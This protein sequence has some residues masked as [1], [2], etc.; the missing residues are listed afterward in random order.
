MEKSDSNRNA[1]G[2]GGEVL[3]KGVKSL[4]EFDNGHSFRITGCVTDTDKIRVRVGT[5]SYDGLHRG[6]CEKF[7]VEIDLKLAQHQVDELVQDG[8]LTL[9]PAARGVLELLLFCS[10]DISNAHKV[11]EKPSMTFE[12]FDDCVDREYLVDRVYPNRNP[13]SFQL[14]TVKRAIWIAHEQEM[15]YAPTGRIS[16]SIPCLSAFLQVQP[17]VGNYSPLRWEDMSAE[18]S[19]IGYTGG[20]ESAVVEQI[21][22]KLF[23]IEAP[24]WN[25]YDRFHTREYHSRSEY[26]TRGELRH[27]VVA[28]MQRC[29]ITPTFTYGGI[30]G[31]QNTDVEFGNC[32]PMPAAL[33]QRLVLLF[34]A[35]FEGK[36]YL[37][38]G[39]EA[40]RQQVF[41]IDRKAIA[42]HD[43]F[44]SEWF[45]TLLN[46]YLNS[47]TVNS[48]YNTHFG[49]AYK[50]PRLC[51]PIMNY[52]QPLLIRFLEDSKIPYNSCCNVEFKQCGECYACRRIKWIRKAGRPSRNRTPLEAGESSCDP[53]IYAYKRYTYQVLSQTKVKSEKAVFEQLSQ[54]VRRNCQAP[55]LLDVFNAGGMVTVRNLSWMGEAD[56][57]RADGVSDK[58]YRIWTERDAALIDE[59]LAQGITPNPH[60]V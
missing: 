20:K 60:T 28:D 22:N 27:C 7:S 35:A 15:Y 58:M 48:Y 46:N 53:G 57:Y 29:E 11:Q 12:A 3:F 25:I 39:D 21:I 51:S 36:Q 54:C 23:K 13:S 59:M 50:S 34:K 31:R 37:F 32:Q 43:F 26:A 47:V 14:A 42:G 55:E 24:L 16:D 2:V 18:N 52:T 56:P 33:V 1:L 5:S 19:A 8:H 45:Y 10:V 40:E 41:I 4:S 44:Q 9:P 30:L 38:V 17:R 49:T 6:N